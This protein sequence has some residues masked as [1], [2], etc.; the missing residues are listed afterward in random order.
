MQEH[1]SRGLNTIRG[2]QIQSHLVSTWLDLT[3]C[4]VLWLLQKPSIPR[5]FSCSRCSELLHNYRSCSRREFFFYHVLF[6]CWAHIIVNVLSLSPLYYLKLIQMEIICLKEIINEYVCW[7]HC[8]PSGRLHLFQLTA[9]SAVQHLQ[10]M[11]TFDKRWVVSKVQVTHVLLVLFLS[12]WS[13]FY[14]TSHLHEKR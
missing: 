7:D 9:A 6:L 10:I 2:C 5:W 13:T 14:S 8:W 11:M 4:T 12:Q 1:F 3:C